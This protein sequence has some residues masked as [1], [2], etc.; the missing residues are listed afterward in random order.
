MKAISSFIK[1]LLN[2][3]L[4]TTLTLQMHQKGIFVY[5]KYYKLHLNSL[6]ECNQ[7]SDISVLPQEIDDRSS[8]I[9]FLMLGKHL[10]CAKNWAGFADVWKHQSIFQVRIGLISLGKVVIVGL[11]LGLF[12]PGKIHARWKFVLTSGLRNFYQYKTD[13]LAALIRRH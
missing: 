1:I 2:R 3:D 11:T 4:E 8:G 6:K 10:L 7:P 9:H 5:I 12:G 13:T